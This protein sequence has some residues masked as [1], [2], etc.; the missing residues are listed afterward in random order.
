MWVWDRHLSLCSIWQVSFPHS[1]F[2]TTS[3]NLLVS[4]FASSFWLQGNLIFWKDLFTNKRCFFNLIENLFIQ[5]KLKSWTIVI[6]TNPNYI[7]RL[8]MGL[9]AQ[10]LLLSGRHH[11]GLY[12]YKYTKGRQVGCVVIHSGMARSHV[13]HISLI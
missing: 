5:C 7:N 9:R 1:V 11:P 4:H 12:T 2:K 8:R 6:L 13:D 10:A 3:K